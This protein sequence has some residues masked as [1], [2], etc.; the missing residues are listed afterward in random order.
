MTVEE[1]V[2]KYK[3]YIT[4]YKAKGLRLGSPAVT[5]DSGLDENKEPKK[6]GVK[7][8]LIPFLDQCTDCQ[9][10]FIALHYY[11]SVPLPPGQDNVANF[12]EYM[13]DAYSQLQK[14]QMPIWVTE[15]GIMR[16][17]ESVEAHQ[18]FMKEV[19]AWMGT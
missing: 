15:V 4:P 16:Q 10:D 14:Y 7:G 5:S 3:Q 1:A 6:V 12:I 8:W 2:A 11:D 9:I 18:K 17:E 13:E 19:T